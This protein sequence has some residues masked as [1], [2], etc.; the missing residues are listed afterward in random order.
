MKYLVVLLAVYF[1]FCSQK[2]VTKG[3]YGALVHDTTAYVGKLKYDDNFNHHLLF[4]DTMLV[5]RSH[6]DSILEKLINLIGFL[7]M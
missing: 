4:I 6:R 1:I 7:G 2:P 3:Y 5:I